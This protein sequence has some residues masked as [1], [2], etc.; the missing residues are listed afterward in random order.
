MTI[1]HNSKATG[2][3]VIKFDVE[4]PELKEQ[5]LFLHLRS[6]AMPMYGKNLINLLWNQQSDGLES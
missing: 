1:S 4:P 3:F 6:S 2:P 5:K